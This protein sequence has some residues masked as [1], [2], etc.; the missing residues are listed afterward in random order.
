MPSYHVSETNPSE[1]KIR[2]KVYHTIRMNCIS[3]GT[4]S[5]PNSTTRLMNRVGN[6]ILGQPTGVNPLRYTPSTNISKNSNNGDGFKLDRIHKEKMASKMLPRLRLKRRVARLINLVKEG[7]QN[8]AFHDEEKSNH[9]IVQD[10]IQSDRR[11][12]PEEKLIYQSDAANVQLKPHKLVRNMILDFDYEE[13]VTRS[14]LSTAKQIRKEAKEIEKYGRPK[15]APNP[16][17]VNDIK[18]EL[19][20]SVDRAKKNQRPL[21]SKEYIDLTFLPRYYNPNPMFPSENHLQRPRSSSSL[22]RSRLHVKEGNIDTT[23]SNIVSKKNDDLDRRRVTVGDKSLA[24][25]FLCKQY[26][27]LPPH[28]FFSLETDN[29]IEAIIK[30]NFNFL[31]VEK[32]IS[33]LK[34]QKFD[35]FVSFSRK[36]Q[37][38]GLIS[39]KKRP[40]YRNRLNLQIHSLLLYSPLHAAADY[41]RLEMVKQILNTNKALVAKNGS[42][43]DLN[44]NVRDIRHGRTP[45][46]YAAERNAEDICR[47][48]VSH[49]AKRRIYDHYG[50]RPSDLIDGKDDQNSMLMGFLKDAPGAIQT[51]TLIDASAYSLTLSWDSPVQ[52]DDEA[53]VEGYKVEYRIVAHRNERFVPPP[54]GMDFFGKHN[55]SF[56]EIVE[57]SNRPE[58]ENDNTSQ[59]CTELGAQSQWQTAYCSPS[60]NSSFTLCLLRPV[61]TY[62]IRV[63]S[64]STTGSGEYSRITTFMTKEGV[65]E[66]PGQPQIYLS[67]LKS[68]SIVWSYPFSDNGFDVQEYIVEAKGFHDNVQENEKVVQASLELASIST[69]DKNLSENDDEASSESKEANQSIPDQKPLQSFLD[70][71][72][73]QLL[74]TEQFKEEDWQTVGALSVSQY[75][76][77]NKRIAF[78]EFNGEKDKSILQQRSIWQFRVSARNKI[79][80]STP[81]KPSRKYTLDNHITV[82]WKESTKLHLSWYPIPFLKILRYELQWREMHATEVE[83]EGPLNG[84]SSISQISDVVQTSDNIDIAKEVLNEYQIYSTDK[85]HIILDNRAE[86]STGFGAMD[87]KI[88]FTLA[89]LKPA[90]YYAIRIRP[91]IKD[92]RANL[93]PFPLTKNVEREIEKVQSLNENMPNTGNEGVTNSDGSI[94]LDWIDA[95]LPDLSFGN[96]KIMNRPLGIRTLDRYPGAP[97]LEKFQQKGEGEIKIGWLPGLPHG[98][99]IN[100]YEIS[101]MDRDR[102]VEVC[103]YLPIK[104]SM[105]NRIRDYRPKHL[106]VKN[107]IPGAS[108]KFRIR[109]K[110]SCGWGE[111]T[112]F[113]DVIT[114]HRV[115]SPSGLSVTSEP[116]NFYGGIVRWEKLNSGVVLPLRYEVK[117][118]PLP[119]RGKISPHRNEQLGKEDRRDT[120]IPEERYSV[121]PNHSSLTIT[122]LRP[123]TSYKCTIR[124]ETNVGFSNWSEGVIFY[125]REPF[126]D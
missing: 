104:L 16:F 55:L 25:Q 107:L 35:H 92:D 105:K 40:D 29:I 1:K 18:D 37:T 19:Y 7:S 38:K 36:L 94:A 103:G 124:V 42:F 22:P 111:Y 10:N 27:S 43:P 9:Y 2:D 21:S 73:K 100:E 8:S 91:V 114:M 20:S 61:S 48:L 26:P 6:I 17:L 32:L 15:S 24:L 101:Y 109:A 81:S 113:S 50:K 119:E 3:K 68:L 84:M 76:V 108:Y 23:K 93:F 66:S 12:R 67:S 74:E 45:L 65:P 121:P 85:M 49:G 82:Y 118:Q 56:E 62:A 44:V 64:Y 115:A 126:H 13:N 70:E 75:D 33:Y 71:T 58:Y 95:I 123:G 112:K 122:D 69:F 117:F 72:K 28:I 63:Q 125:T 60:S 120:I 96:N 98:Q 77:R 34:D 83:K 99:P 59:E 41:G 46:H 39:D 52:K 87:G 116:N 5:N 80:W 90:T 53:D 97:T 106:L 14:L 51:V 86:N 78:F 11:F 4:F 89:A 102:R 88:T 57:E 30:N 79:G 31:T 54:P 47:L 110:N